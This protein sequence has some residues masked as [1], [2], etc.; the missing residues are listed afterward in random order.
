MEN[1]KGVVQ[2]QEYLT[3]EIIQGGYDSSIF[4]EYMSKLK[5]TLI[6]KR[7]RY[8][9]MVNGRIKN[10]FINRLLILLKKHN[11]FQFLLKKLKELLL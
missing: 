11:K 1:E 9:C 10:S 8:Q 5:S 6:S 2:R 7:R 4:V 3:K